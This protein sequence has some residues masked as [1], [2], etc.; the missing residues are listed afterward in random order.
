[1]ILAVD[2]HYKGN[3]ATV[4]GVT[5]AYWSSTSE[6]SIYSSRLTGIEDYVPGEFFRRELPCILH[7]LAEHALTPDSIVVDG[8]VF[9]DGY[10]TPGL[11]KH[12]FDALHQRIPVIGVAKSRFVAAPDGIKLYRGRSKAPLYVT[13]VGI[14]LAEAIECVQSMHG[15]HR[16]PFMLKMADQVS[17]TIWPNIKCNGPSEGGS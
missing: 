14:P 17:R 12:L 16:I 11:G 2:V 6:D 7:L 3:A 15:Q 10:T 9:L 4:G 13:S 1:M 5:F 8:F